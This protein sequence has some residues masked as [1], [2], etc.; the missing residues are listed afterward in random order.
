M[1]LPFASVIV[2]PIGPAFARP[3]AVPIEVLVQKHAVLDLSARA[4]G[5]DHALAAWAIRGG[6]ACRADLDLHAGP[7]RPP[8]HRHGEG[9]GGHPVRHGQTPL[10]QAPR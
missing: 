8:R 1:L 3:A 9:G 10:W 6:L 2:Y 7:R 5:R 4:H